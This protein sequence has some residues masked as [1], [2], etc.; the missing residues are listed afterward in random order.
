[1]ERTAELLGVA[2]RGVIAVG[3][4]A[5]LIAVPGDRLQDISVLG[6]LRF[7]VKDGTVYLRR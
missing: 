6:R 4:L 1:M 7:V 5:D 3:R 2:D